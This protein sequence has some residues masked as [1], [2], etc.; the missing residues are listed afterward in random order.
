MKREELTPDQ[1]NRKEKLLAR[2]MNSSLFQALRETSGIEEAF[3]IFSMWIISKQTFELTADETEEELFCGGFEF[4]RMMFEKCLSARGIGDVGASL[5]VQQE[6]GEEKRFTHKRIHQ[7]ALESMFGTIQINRLGYGAR[8]EK[9]IH[10]LDEELNLPK[11]KYSFQVQKRAIK[12]CGRG[13][14][15]E[16]VETVRETTA[17]NLPKRQIAEIAVK[18]AQDFKEFYGVRRENMSSPEETGPLVVVGTDGKGVRN[19]RTREEKRE[20][21][22]KRLAKGEKNSKKKMATVATIHTTKPYFRTPEEVVSRLMDKEPVEQENKRPEAEERRLWA[23]LHKSKAE[24][25]EEIVEEVEHRDPNHEKTVLFLA[26]GERALKARAEE[27]LKVAFPNLVMILD[28]IHATEYLWKAAYVFLKEGSREAFQWVKARLLRVLRGEVRGVVQGIRSMA[29]RRTLTVR[30]AKLIET[31]CGYFL[32]NQ[33]R[34]KYDEYL[35][36]GYPIASGSVEGACGHL[37]KDRMERSGS[38]W[39]VDGEV[40]EAILKIRALDKS[41]DLEEYWKF[42]VEKQRYDNYVRQW[43]AAA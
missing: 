33:G 10:P 27:S 17:A 16:A 28:V 35:K 7:R 29:S 21:A 38:S 31:I 40:A 22:G 3:S 41:G 14:F 34:M 5:F 39:K 1:K 11:Q 32:N 25:F 12:L 15:D 19:R 6:N 9:S 8:G 24:V 13:P 42:H 20:Q 37:V 36:K 30:K 43:S 2:Q 26:D 4:L 18:S 23:S